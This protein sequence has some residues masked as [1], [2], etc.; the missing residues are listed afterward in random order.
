M[1]YK[2]ILS[3]FIVLSILVMCLP[4]MPIAVSAATGTGTV[5]D[6]VIIKT[7]QDFADY[8][9]NGV[10]ESQHKGKYFELKSD[11][12]LPDD[13]VPNSKSTKMQ[14]FDGKGHSITINYSGSA[15]Y[16]SVFGSWDCGDVSAQEE[17]CL[18][19]LVV[20]GSVSGGISVNAAGAVSVVDGY[21]TYNF[22]NIVDMNAA[23]EIKVAK[24]SSGVIKVYCEADLI[25]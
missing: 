5:D 8:F 24:N 3:A 20:K 13:F 6:P 17:F 7:A 23:Y 25:K 14:S 18:K 1:N 2:R 16:P 19:N 22:I 10:A 11:I 4:V 15:T 9:A 12:I 21:G